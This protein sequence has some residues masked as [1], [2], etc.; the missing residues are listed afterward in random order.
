VTI[1]A[2]C[3]GNVETKSL[4]HEAPAGLAAR[5]GRNERPAWLAPVPSTADQPL[6]LFRVVLK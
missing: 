6:K 2:S 1:V 4:D 5:L 3:P